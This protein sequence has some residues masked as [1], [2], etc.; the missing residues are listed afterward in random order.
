MESAVCY[1]LP[2][3]CQHRT[4]SGVTYPYGQPNRSIQTLGVSIEVVERVETPA[5]RLSSG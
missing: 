2:G 5:R 1:L 4:F 3:R